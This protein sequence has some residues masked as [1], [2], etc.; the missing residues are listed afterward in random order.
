MWYP[1]VLSRAVTD[2]ALGVD[3]VN[4]KQIPAPGKHVR[5]AA[6]TKRGVHRFRRCRVYC[7]VVT[8]FMLWLGL[9]GVIVLSHTCMMSVPTT[10]TY[11]TLSVEKSNS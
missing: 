6:A 1:G 7:G 8:V 10:L 5:L 2:V 3:P 11:G 4:E 9:V